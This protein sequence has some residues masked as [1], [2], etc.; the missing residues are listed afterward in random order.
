MDSN[1]YFKVEGRRPVTLLLYVDDMLLK[2]KEELFKVARRRLA[3]EFE[4]KD[5]VMML[6]F[7]GMGLWQTMDGISLGKGKY[8]IEILKRFRMMACK[9][10]TTPMASNLKLL[11]NASSESVDATMYCQMIYLT[12][13]RPDI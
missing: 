12:N 6:C 1:L 13:M 10:M 8:A 7:L 11:S 3:F 4:L 9:A 5:L 2:R